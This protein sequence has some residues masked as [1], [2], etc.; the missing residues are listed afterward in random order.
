MA[1]DPVEKFISENVHYSK[2][3]DD[4]LDVHIGNPLRR[5]TEL[6][7][8]IKRQKAFSFT[9]KGSLGIAG[10]ILTLSILGI[11]G[12]GNLLCAKGVQKQIGVVKVLNIKEKEPPAI[13]LFSDV[14]DLFFARP[15]HNSV[16]LVKS[17]DTVITLPYSR[18]VSLNQYA[19][20]PVI[21]TGDYDSCGQT[22]TIKDPTAIEIYTSR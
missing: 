11:L 19:S 20:L 10:V 21:A 18:S 22:L 16:V 7:E 8:E 13:P 9:L 1:K 14:I 12:A 6:L 3:K 5:I 15:K 4:L 2:N 17:D